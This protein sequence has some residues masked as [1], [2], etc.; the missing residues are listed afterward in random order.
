MSFRNSIG[1]IYPHEL[2]LKITTESPTV[3]SYLDLSISIINNNFQ[4]DL[5]DKG[6]AFG[7]RIVNFQHMDSNIPSK[8]AYSVFI[9]QLVRF[10]WVCVMLRS[11][12]LTK[13]LLKQGFNYTRLQNTLGKFLRSN[14]IALRK[15]QVSH[16]TL[17]V[18]CISLPLSGFP[19]LRH[20]IS[21]R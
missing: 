4:T 21:S 18:E 13:R 14:P 3:C 17:L 19:S 5:Y 20:H 15:Y 11:T 16:K 8:P 6:D 2:E 12:N 1:K 9:S 10:L 7:F